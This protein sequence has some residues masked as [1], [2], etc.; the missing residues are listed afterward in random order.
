MEKRGSNAS[1]PSLRE[2]REVRP[3]FGFFQGSGMKK[4][5]S[6]VD[7]DQ[8]RHRLLGIASPSEAKRLNV[9]PEFH[10]ARIFVTSDRSSTNGQSWIPAIIF[11]R[12]YEMHKKELA[13]VDKSTSQVDF[14]AA[15][16]DMKRGYGESPLARAFA[17]A[18]QA[19]P[20][21]G[22]AVLNNPPLTLLACFCRALAAEDERGKQGFFLSCADAGKLLGVSDMTAHRQLLALCT[23]GVLEIVKKGTRREGGGKATRYRYIAKE[24]P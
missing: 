23:L 21:P 4:G 19:T 14:L 3:N 6:Q 22:V 15:Y 10:A 17:E 5:M 24:Q 18:E 13:G 20:P 8:L 2:G 11:E 16:A 1:L 9:S 12:W 7:L